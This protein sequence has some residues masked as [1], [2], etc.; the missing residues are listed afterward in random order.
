MS[1]GQIKNKLEKNKNKTK[2]CTLVVVV[3]VGGGWG[4]DDNDDWKRGRVMCPGWWGELVLV[5]ETS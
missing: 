3:V 4:G 1:V 5:T 2:H